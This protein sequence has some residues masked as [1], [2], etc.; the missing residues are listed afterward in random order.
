MIKSL[1]A[2]KSLVIQRE[3]VPDDRRE[4]RLQFKVKFKLC[5]LDPSISYEGLT[6]LA[7]GSMI[8]SGIRVFFSHCH[9]P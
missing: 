5:Y 9:L 4:K 6:L 2:Y 7:F 8:A 3:F 1:V